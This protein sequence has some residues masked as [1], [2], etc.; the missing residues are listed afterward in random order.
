MCSCEGYVC[1]FV[2]VITKSKFVRWVASAVSFCFG[3]NWR[4]HQTGFRL[5]WLC[6]IR[7]INE[8]THVNLLS[9][10]TLPSPWPSLRCKTVYVHTFRTCPSPLPRARCVFV[11]L[12]YYYYYFI[13]GHHAKSASAES[14]SYYVTVC[15][16]VHLLTALLEIKIDI[17]R[18]LSKENIFDNWHPSFSQ[19]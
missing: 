17:A 6:S 8:K 7:R 1:V 9:I 13:F 19:R 4:L 16:C 15:L 18:F 2:A 10:W 11:T 5:I 12:H 14:E 3:R